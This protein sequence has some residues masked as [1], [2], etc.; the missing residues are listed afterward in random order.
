MTAPSGLE[1]LRRQ[2][3]EFAGADSR[4]EFFIR[5][6]QQLKIHLLPM[7][8]SPL[9]L[10]FIV[11]FFRLITSDGGALRFFHRG[12]LRCLSFF[13]WLW[14]QITRVPTINQKHH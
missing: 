12:S 8:F 5:V 10:L 11:D 4:L 9:S 3:L 1:P 6:D 2:F 14:L 13:L 7:P